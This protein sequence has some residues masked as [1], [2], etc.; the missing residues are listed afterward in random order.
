MKN[1]WKGLIIG[2]LTGVLA[3]YVLDGAARASKKATAL[4]DSVLEH[5]PEAGRF[6]QTVTEKAGDWL[7]ETDVPEQVKTVAHKLK[8]SEAAA[9][10]ADVGHEI[11]S[12]AREKATSHSR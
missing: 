8:D 7:H 4:G 12:A 5:T 6:V 3:G 1:V 9:R 11:V 2:G 10:V